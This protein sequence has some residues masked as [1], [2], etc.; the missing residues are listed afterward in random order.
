MEKNCMSCF[1][2]SCN[3]L[4]LFRNNFTSLFY[5]DA[6]LDKSI[7]DIFVVDSLAFKCFCEIGKLIGKK[8]VVVTDNDGNVEDNIKKKY[9]GYVG[10]PDFAFYFEKD[11]TLHTIEPSVLAVNSSDGIPSEIFRQAISARGSMMHKNYDEILSFMTANKAEWAYR[12]FEADVSVSFP[13]YIINV[14]KHF[15]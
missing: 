3:L 12:V 1:V 8:V 4:F 9:E 11:E 6:N 10:H 5:A 15:E 7:I 13:E 2:V 14:V